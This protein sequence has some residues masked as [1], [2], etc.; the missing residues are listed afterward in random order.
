MAVPK[1]KPGKARSRRRRT[2]NMR[3]I[4]PTLATCSTCGNVI[5]R[6]HLCAKCGSYRGRQIIEV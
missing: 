4:A 2:I 5:T 3:L 6:H 1:Y